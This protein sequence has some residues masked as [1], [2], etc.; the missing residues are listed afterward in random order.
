[1]NLY[2]TQSIHIHS[3]K[4]DTITTS[5]V[6]QIGSTGIIKTLSASSNMGAQATEKIPNS[7]QPKSRSF[8]ISTP[9]N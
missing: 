5:S 1:M 8:Q 3:I 6:F 9:T 7:S 4:I 2:I